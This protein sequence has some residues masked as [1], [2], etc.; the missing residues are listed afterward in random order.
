[1][2]IGKIDCNQSFQ[3]LNFNNV[4]TVDRNFIKKDFKKLKE[5]GKEYDIRLTSVYSNSPDGEII[6]VDVKPLNKNLSFW[7]KLF[8]PIGRDSFFTNETSILESVYRA[9]KDLAYKIE[10]RKN[11]HEFNTKFAEE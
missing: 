4:S 11:K 6:D 8:P 1:M 9:I 5:L 10:K 7:E 3:A 2:N